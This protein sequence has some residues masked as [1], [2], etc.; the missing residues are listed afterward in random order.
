M[1]FCGDNELE[2][3]KEADPGKEEG[4]QKEFFVRNWCR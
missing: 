1:R 3:E 4:V 2:E